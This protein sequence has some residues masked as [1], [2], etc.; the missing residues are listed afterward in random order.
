MVCAAASEA[1]FGEVL[2]YCICS[3]AAAVTTGFGQWVASAAAGMQ[4]ALVGFFTLD[5]VLALESRFSVIQGLD[6]Q[7]LAGGL[8]S[9]TGEQA[10]GRVDVPSK[11]NQQHAAAAIET[12]C[13]CRAGQAARCTQVWGP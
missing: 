7:V 9:G 10:S 5:D 6:R 1:A 13:F 8:F 4:R 3:S 12:V 2:L 11:D